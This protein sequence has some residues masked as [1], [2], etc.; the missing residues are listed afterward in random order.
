MM[1]MSAS[2]L[3]AKSL[4]RKLAVAGAL[5]A[6]AVPSSLAA[7]EVTYEYDVHG[8]LIK[9]REATASTSREARYSFDR[10][11]NRL[12]HTVTSSGGTATRRVVVVSLRGYKVIFVAT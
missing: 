1:M 10:A 4:P 7:S 9:A 2:R 8:R 3:R 6:S 5:A 11:D 12:S